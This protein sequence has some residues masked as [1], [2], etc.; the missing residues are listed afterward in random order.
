MSCSINIY[1]NAFTQI[2]QENYEKLSK[3]FGDE[4][5]IY[6]KN[7]I[8]KN[9][10][11][12]ILFPESYGTDEEN[13][14]LTDIEK[15]SLTDIP[16][17]FILGKWKAMKYALVSNFSLRVP[18]Y[19]IEE[20]YPNDETKLMIIT[21]DAVVKNHKKLVN[22]AFLTNNTLLLLDLVY[23][24]YSSDKSDRNNFIINNFMIN[25]SKINILHINN[26]CKL[27]LHG[28]KLFYN[29][30]DDIVVENN[31][32]DEKQTYLLLF[33]K[34]EQTYQITFNGDIVNNNILLNKNM[35]TTIENI[36]NTQYEKTLNLVL[37]NS[38]LSAV[39]KLTKLNMLLINDLPTYENHR[40]I[41][42]TLKDIV[43]KT[44]KIITTDLE[45]IVFKA[46]NLYLNASKKIKKNSYL[47]LNI[48]TLLDMIYL[49]NNNEDYTLVS[50]DFSNSVCQITGVNI[51]N[52]ASNIIESF[53]I[54]T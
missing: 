50:G 34:I 2:Q 27:I 35:Q 48:S 45:K 3:E 46:F 4:Y 17:T 23:I 14:F 49:Y 26:V 25:K 43:D 28:I 53:E 38:Y 32:I 15:I 1:T 31:Y 39:W 10:L 8:Y 44:E 16:N 13:K 42:K 54:F 37:Q 22:N 5:A 47:E 6:L 33:N 51:I 12:Q 19:T 18:Q 11:Y 29:M 36:E 21:F 24:Y 7:I 40:N 30:K 41:F 52:L 9:E 20:K